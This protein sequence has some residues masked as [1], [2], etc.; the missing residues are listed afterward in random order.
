MRSA[1][2]NHLPDQDAQSDSSGLLRVPEGDGDSEDS[3][4]S[5]GSDSYDPDVHAS[6]E[7]SDGSE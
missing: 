5:I 3:S 2:D 4:G 1:D 7:E 6:S